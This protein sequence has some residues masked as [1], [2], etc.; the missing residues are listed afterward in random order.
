[1]VRMLLNYGADPVMLDANGEKPLSPSAQKN[2]KSAYTDALFSS[3]AQHEYFFKIKISIKYF[4]IISNDIFFIFVLLA[5]HQD[6]HDR[7]IVFC[8][9]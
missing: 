4:Y 7:K 1:M 6:E 8:Y 2:T 5:M 9:N 3:I